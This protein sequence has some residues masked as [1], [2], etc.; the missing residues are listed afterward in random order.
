MLTIAPVEYAVRRALGRR[1]TLRDMASRTW[2]VE[3]ES[4]QS[5]PKATFIESTLSRVTAPAP[6]STLKIQFDM[7]AGGEATHLPVRALLIRDAALVGS[8]VYVRGH[9]SPLAPEGGFRLR[10]L[11]AGV[12]VDKAALG[13]T[14]FG[15]MFFGHFWTDD[16]PLMQL[17]GE[18]AEPVRTSR[19]LTGHQRELLDLL[20]LRPRLT[21][22]LLLDELFVFEDSA[23]TPS[24][25]RR[26]RKIRELFAARF[27]RADPPRGV[28]VFRGK[29]GTA[30]VLDNEAQVAE[31]LS[32]HGIVPVHP[33]RMT[34]AELSRAIWGARLVVG[35]EGSQMVHGIYNIADGGAFLALQPPMRFGNIIKNYT[36]C[37][38]MRYGFVVGEPSATGFTVSVDEVLRVIDMLESRGG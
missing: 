22:S 14:Y 6:F 35:V 21:S 3:P 12:R 16:V 33:E 27:G 4:S 38:K 32:R 18:T 7:I 36:D 2:I 10:D 13:C 17:A 30:R 9:R 26:Y 11:G 28:F 29:S 8:S 31:A 23:Q 19:S 24:K 20:G 1:R 15:N 34:L 5:V 37:L 25:A